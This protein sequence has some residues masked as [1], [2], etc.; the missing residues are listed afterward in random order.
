MT[1]GCLSFVPGSHKTHSIAKRFVRMDGGGTGFIEIGKEKEE[2]DASAFK[3]E[4]CPAGKED[5]NTSN[6]RNSSHHPRKRRTQKRSK[7]KREQSLHLHLSRDR[8]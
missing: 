6:N 5:S 7:S 8:R 2:P 4:E 1:N 3:V